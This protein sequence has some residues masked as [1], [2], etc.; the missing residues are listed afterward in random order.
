VCVI[1]S[2]CVCSE[3][4]AGGERAMLELE[5]LLPMLQ[6]VARV[7]KQNGRALQR[8]QAVITAA[9]PLWGLSCPISTGLLERS[10][11]VLPR[12]FSLDQKAGWKGLKYGRACSFTCVVVAFALGSY[13]NGDRWGVSSGLGDID[14]KEFSTGDVWV[15]FSLHGVG[16]DGL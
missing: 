8:Y 10:F 7:L 5:H 16:G 3:L 11:F 2:V 12:L 14:A 9:M 6:Q 1:A 13:D 4:F 15:S